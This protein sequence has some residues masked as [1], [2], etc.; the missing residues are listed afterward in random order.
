[1][2]IEFEYY[3]N[4]VP[5]KGK[6]RN[7]LIYT[8]L[9]SN[10]QKTF[11]QWYHND[12]EYHKGRNEVVDSSLMD[13]KFNREVQYLSLMG[14]H[15]PDLVPTYEIDNTTRKIYLE[16]DGP[17]LWELAGCTGTDYS[18]VVPDWKEQ[19]LNIIQ[20]HKT[21]GLYKYAMHPSSYFVINGK[22]KSI[23]YFFTYHKSE[24]RIQVGDVLSHISLDRR[25][26]LLPLMDAL[27]I[28][29]NE[30]KSFK[31]Y[32]MLCFD[33]FSNNFSTDFIERAKNIYV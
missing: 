5:E 8:S 33:S 13:E 17:D 18:A 23:N 10:D 22:L 7:N 20:A 31:D 4:N 6:C 15:Y 1:M 2:S 14:E 9:M 29:I 16:V 19:M 27:N 30:S 24:P 28:N 26:A 21:L 11:V 12:S 3:Y 25:K 32:H